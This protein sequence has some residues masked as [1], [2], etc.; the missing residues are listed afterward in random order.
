[1]F[2]A[3]DYLNKNCQTCTIPIYFHIS[4]TALK[5]GV[6]RPIVTYFPCFNAEKII[7]LITFSKHLAHTEPIFKSLNILP[8]NS[9]YYHRIGL[10]M[11]KLSNGLLPEA[12]NELYIKRN[13]IHN[14]PTRNCDKY[15]IQTSTDSFSNVSARIWNVIK[16][17]ID[18]NI[19]FMQFKIVL[20]L[21]LHE[22]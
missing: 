9:L 14:Y 11:D 12:L 22:N 18:V 13:K 1:M 3:R 5:C 17:N 2:K 21:Y 4:F 7:R 6:M 16:T 15:H 19:S 10:L 20:K 8:L